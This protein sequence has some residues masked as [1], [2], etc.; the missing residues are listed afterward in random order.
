MAFHGILYSLKYNVK[1]NAVCLIESKSL[2][3]PFKCIG[4]R[5]ALNEVERS[6]DVNELSELQKKGWASNLITA[7]AGLAPIVYDQIK[8]RFG[9]YILYFIIQKLSFI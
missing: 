8:S 6:L 4:K 7:G 9:K 2:Y 5:G 3:S 1:F